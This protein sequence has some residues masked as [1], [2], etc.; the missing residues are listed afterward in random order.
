[1]FTFEAATNLQDKVTEFYE[2]GKVCAALCHGAALLRYTRLSNGEPLV[3]GKTV[4]GFANLDEDYVDQ[5]V[6]DM[7]ALSRPT[8]TSCRGA[9]RTS[10]ALG[11]QL[12]PGRA[13]EGLRH[14]RR[15]PDHRTTDLQ[16]GR[17]R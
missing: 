10:K 4:A 12:H 7:V 2:A 14:P 16:R 11:A 13:V 6:C 3:A 9:S 17:H 8:G 1:M 5:S 15:E